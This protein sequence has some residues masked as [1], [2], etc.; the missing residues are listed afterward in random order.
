MKKIM[1]VTIVGSGI[2]GLL[3]AKALADA[4]LSVQIIEK[5]AGSLES[6]WAGGGILLPLYPWQQ[7]KAISEL[8]SLSLKLYPT[9][10]AQLIQATHIDPE[11]WQC[12]LLVSKN[13]EIETAIQW[14]DNYNVEYHLASES[15]FKSFQ[16][17]PLNPLWLPKI[18]QA[19]NPRLLKSL[20][21][22][23]SQHHQVTFVENCILETFELHKNQVTKIKTS[24]GKFSINHLVL[25]TGAW[26]GTLTKSLFPVNKTLGIHPVKGQMILLDANVGDLSFMI[27]DQQR[28]LIPRRDG[29]ILVGST[30]EK[31]EFNKSV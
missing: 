29:K 2:I 4:G 24:L 16:T 27:L 18:A 6:S 26:T 25:A 5:N 22:F 15:F 11:W 13:S 8:V 7:K 28:Y 20:R 12:G 23:L 31:T 17:N 3:T 9:L 19:R 30:V 1:D 21:A 10:S 14:C